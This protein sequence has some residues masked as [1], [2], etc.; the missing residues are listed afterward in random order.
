MDLINAWKME[1][2]KSTD[3]CFIERKT[4]T[5]Q[6]NVAFLMK[7]RKFYRNKSPS[8][9]QSKDICTLNYLWGFRD[10]LTAIAMRVV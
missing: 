3:L 8:P 4:K 9:P 1:E 5:S 10:H 2:I 7:K 6:S